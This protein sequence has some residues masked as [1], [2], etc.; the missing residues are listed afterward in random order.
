MKW[1]F[2]PDAPEHA[3]GEAFPEAPTHDCK[4]AL[5]AAAAWVLPV[6]KCLREGI[7]NDPSTLMHLVLLHSVA[8]AKRSSEASL[9]LHYAVKTGCVYF[10]RGIY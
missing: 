7:V 5:I 8:L 4:Y 1:Y 2:P 3:A 6:V 9:F 10:R